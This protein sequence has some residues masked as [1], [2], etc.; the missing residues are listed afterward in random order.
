MFE[1]NRKMMLCADVGGSVRDYENMILVSTG[2]PYVKCPHVPSV[3]TNTYELTR[4]Y[5]DASEIMFEKI[6]FSSRVIGKV[7][8]CEKCNKIYYED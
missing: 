7:G 5:F 1:V 6:Y 3:S 8:R 2:S 4:P